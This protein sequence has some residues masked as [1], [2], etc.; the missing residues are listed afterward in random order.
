MCQVLLTISLLYIRA[1]S[2]FSFG[3]SQLLLDSVVFDLSFDRNENVCCSVISLSRS[4]EVFTHELHLFLQEHP[5]FLVNAAEYRRCGDRTHSEDRSRHSDRRSCE[6][7]HRR[8]KNKTDT[9]AYYLSFCKSHDELLFD[10]V[11]VLWDRYIMCHK[12]S[13]LVLNVR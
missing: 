1:V 3:I 12:T 4:C 5:V 11:Q 8:T 2:A 7:V 9:E 6:K 13:D 10:V